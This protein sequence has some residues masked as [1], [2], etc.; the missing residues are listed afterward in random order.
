VRKEYMNNVLSYE[1][2]RGVRVNGPGR[3]E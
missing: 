2:V 3:A 1:G